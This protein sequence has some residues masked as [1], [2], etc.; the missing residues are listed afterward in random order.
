MYK[1]QGANK[2]LHIQKCVSRPISMDLVATV[3]RSMKSWEV[4]IGLSIWK[5]FSLGSEER[6]E[7][8]LQAYV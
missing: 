8:I 6:V 4:S 2:L 5:L 1:N 7:Q 3:G